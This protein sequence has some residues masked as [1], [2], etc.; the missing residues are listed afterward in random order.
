MKL[1]SHL[2]FADISF[3]SNDGKLVCEC[4]NCLKSNHVFRNRYRLVRDMLTGEKPD[5]FDIC[6][7]TSAGQ[8]NLKIHI[9]I[10]TGEKPSYSYKLIENKNCLSILYSWKDPRISELGQSNL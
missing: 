6:P 4:S 9:R 3:I 7:K 2:D 5:A 10:N 8:E 1:S